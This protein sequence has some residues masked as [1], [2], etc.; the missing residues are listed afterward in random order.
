[1]HDVFRGIEALEDQRDKLVAEL[2]ALAV[3]K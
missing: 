1:L 2:A 3:Q